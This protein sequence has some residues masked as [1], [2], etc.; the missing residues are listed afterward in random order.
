MQAAIAIVLTDANRNVQWVNQNFTDITGYSLQEVVGK[1][2]SLLQG[3]GTPSKDVERIREKLNAHQPVKDS[4]V[5][6][7]KDGKAY[8]CTFV[9]HPIFGTDGKLT[10]YIAFEADGS[11]NDITKIPLLQLNEKEKYATSSIKFD[12]QADLY[13]RLCA[14]VLEEK[15]YLNPDLGLSD[16]ALKMHTNTRY[17]SQVINS[18]SGFNL[19]HFLNVY[20]IEEVKKQITS[21]G[22]G[23]FTLY[24]IAQKSGF[25]NKSTFYKVFKEIV[26]TTPKDF[27]R[28][29]FVSSHLD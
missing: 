18:H 11:Q 4:L 7:T 25:K 29:S 28:D 12:E 2:P 13:V 15:L 14:L 3:G 10:N 8:K 22:F 6:Y 9:I 19:Q 20:R 27:L 16:L 17:L 1:K 21:D 24:G 23:S 5:N 26:G